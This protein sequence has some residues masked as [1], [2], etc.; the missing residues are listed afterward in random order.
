M[1]NIKKLFAKCVIALIV[2]TGFNCAAGVAAAIFIPLIGA[3]QWTNLNDENNT[4][5][6]I[7]TN[8]S[9]NI[10]SF[11]GNENLPAGGQAHFT[12]GFNNHDIHFTYN[13]DAGVTRAGKTYKGT[14]NDASTVMSLNGTDAVD[15]LPPLTLEK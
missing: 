9:T 5:F 14:I 2:I 13:S 3:A 8:D 4:F 6:F 12:G 1:K 15:P 10:S 11:E 7:V